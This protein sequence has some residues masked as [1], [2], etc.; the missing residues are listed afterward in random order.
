MF[1]CGKKCKIK[2]S[3]NTPELD[4]GEQMTIRLSG[5][6]EVRADVVVEIAKEAGRIIMDIYNTD[7]DK[8]DIVAKSD[9]SPLTRAD[10][11]ANDYICAQLS[12]RYPSIPM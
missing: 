1:N 8:W 5:G 2:S 11:A 9:N 12:E 4:F 10:L 6:V 3:S 7:V